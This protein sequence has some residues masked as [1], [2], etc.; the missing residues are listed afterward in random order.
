MKKAL[1]KTYRNVYC[2]H[3]KC[4][5]FS[6][7]TGLTVYEESFIDGMLVSSGWNAAGYPLNVLQL[8]PSGIDHREFAEPQA[9]RLDADGETADS[10]LKFV[11]FETEECRKGTHATV[12]LLCEH[13]NLEIAVHTYLDGTACFTRSIE[14]K[15]KGDKA[16]AINR[17][18]VMSGGLE[19]LGDYHTL[20][21]GHNADE[22]YTL[23]YFDSTAWGKEGNFGWHT[24]QQDKTVFSGR[25]LRSRHRHPMFILKNKVMGTTWIAQLA[26]SAGYDFSFDYNSAPEEFRTKLAFSMDMTSHSPMLLLEPGETFMSPE[27]YIG[28]V[29]GDEDDAVNAMN[30]H[31]RRSVFY[32]TEEITSKMLVG[33]GMGAEHDMLVSTTKKYME[34]MAY[35]G[36]DVFIVDAGWYTEPFGNIWTRIGDWHPNEKRYPNGISEISDYCHSLGMKFGLWMESE[37]ISAS[38][39]AEKHPDWFPVS[40]GGGTIGTFID[41][42]NEDAFNWVKSEIERVIREYKLDLFRVDYNVDTDTLLGY[43]DKNGRKEFNTLRHVKAVYRLYSEI[44]KEFPDVIF[45]N[46]AGGGGRTDLGHIVNFNHTWVSD[47]QTAPRSFYITNG[48]S[49]A[50]PPERVD[51]L[52]AG[53]GCHTYAS[54]DFQ[55]RNAMFG[56]ISMNVFSPPDAEDNLQQLDFI[57]HSI[58]LYKEIARPML[59]TC[60][61]YHHTPSTKEIQDGGFG[62]I[63][64]ASPEGDVSMIGIF[65]FPCAKTDTVTVYP[66][67]ITADGNYEVYFDNTRSKGVRSGTD[68]INSGIRVRISSVMSSELIVLKKV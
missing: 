38:E 54:L 43:K 40:R 64:N 16:V 4:P 50:I 58:D 19:V 26:W 52:V 24:L 55:M 46:C 14:V 53:M 32:E 68:I 36:C 47:N 13:K 28:I 10:F 21:D 8:I 67:G 33:A 31:L 1:G 60:R 30:E 39:I 41:L 7:R 59:P 51:R 44:R 6:Y 56:H 2:R 11:G 45:E 42:T 3:D 17:F 18:A 48:M 63:E 37:R 5:V 23:G 34:Q 66:R 61:I 65:T 9:F 27:V 22:I 57:K 12:K 35:I 25:F 62:I 20:A 29:S 49:M 15:N